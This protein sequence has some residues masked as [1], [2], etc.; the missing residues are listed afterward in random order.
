MRRAWYKI[1]MTNIQ[2]MFGAL[3][4]EV[5]EEFAR[6][7]KELLRQGRQ[8]MQGLDRVRLDDM[9]PGEAGMVR[10]LSDGLDD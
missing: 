7:R 9:T 1:T 3:P 8:G 2:Q 6:V 10:E 5:G 4:P